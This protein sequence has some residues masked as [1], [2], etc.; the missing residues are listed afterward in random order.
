MHRIR[1]WL[2]LLTLFP[3]TLLAQSRLPKLETLSLSPSALH[4]L[5]QMGEAEWITLTLL[6][7]RLSF[8]AAEQDWI[9]RYTKALGGL[10]STPLHRLMLVSVP[11]RQLPLLAAL[12]SLCTFSLSL[13]ED[14]PLSMN[15][16]RSN[17]QAGG[18]WLGIN[19]DSVHQLGYRGQG[20][21]VGIV[22]LGF[23]IYNPDFRKPDNT[24]RIL[25]LWH[26]GAVGTPPAGFT[27]GA[28]YSSAEIDAHS[29]SVPN[30]AHGTACLGI[31]AGN[32]Q[33]SG[34]AGIAPEA[35]ILLVVLANTVDT[36][37]I[38]AFTYLKQKATALGKPISIS[39][40]YGSNF[41]AHDGTRSTELAISSL[42]GAGTLFSVAGGNNGGANVHIDAVVPPSGQSETSFTTGP[43]NASGFSFYGHLWY[44]GAA[45][46]AVT[47]IAPDN[48]EYGPF[49]LSSSVQ[50][51]TP[52]R[53]YHNVYAPNGDKEVQFAIEN[54]PHESG[55]RVRLTNLGSSA[56]PY[57]GWRVHGGFWTSNQNNS[58]SLTT[59]STAD[60]AICVVAYDVSTGHREPTSSIGLTRHNKPKPEV[61]APTN[62]TTTN[63]AFGGTSAAAP[64]L[65]GLGALLLQANPTLSTSEFRKILADSSRRDVATGPIPPHKADWGYGKQY[66]LGAFQAAL[67]KSG[68]SVAITRT[69]NFIWNDQSGQYGV[70]LSF[71][72]E[73][74]DQVTVEIS[75]NTAPSFSGSAKAVKR[76]VVITS[77]GGSGTFSATLRI[78]YTDAEVAAGGLSEGNLKLYRLNGT[79]W[80]LK[81]GINNPVE[82]YVE[83]S[84]VTAFSEWAIADPMDH[85]LPVELAAFYGNATPTG[86]AL[87]WTTASEIDNAGF[88]VRRSESG[89]AFETI[90]SY[91][92]LP[93][94]KG[95]GTTSQPSHYHFLDVGVKAGIDYTYR[96]R[97]VDFNGIM[98][99]YAH[100]V[101]VRF[102]LSGQSR[103]YD[104]A[105][106]QN[107]PNPFNPTTV[108]KYSLRES[109]WV[110]LKIYDVLGREVATLVH[111]PQTAGE[112]QV[113]LDAQQLSASGIYICQLRAGA[114]TKTIKMMLIK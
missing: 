75:P 40:S 11:I 90:A 18:K 65:A 53:V 52:V 62:V 42:A 95:R 35:D 92:F 45:S 97:S 111:Q 50:V 74:I 61:T 109:G 98:H 47:L 17:Q 70:F 21:I 99:D 20:T 58:R 93:S 9:V 14:E 63:S 60:S 26:Q 84:G 39:Y 4:R 76:R 89:A 19:A 23:D 55:W 114:V 1:L 69:G 34:Q 28:E 94:L 64:H 78:Y 83:L 41:G 56:V 81:G 108:I 113:I 102:S 38:R 37:V 44:S 6:P 105:L 73:D 104:Y 48:T 86:I 96:L 30:N 8:S 82:N 12:D 51:L 15:L 67:P 49:G 31:A 33:A 66:A 101:T 110:S 46:I 112:Y 72:S 68:Q 10:A 29:V 59:P 85:P 22:D 77:V 106:A 43:N 16:S 91:Q 100:T 25:H 79:N 54:R 27:F 88:E 13:I 5:S 24:T 87:S 7:K 36:S 57:D 107:Y 71:V 3:L 80:E 32:G 2:L 103:Q